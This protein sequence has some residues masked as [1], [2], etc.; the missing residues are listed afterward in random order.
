V[1]VGD[2]LVRARLAGAHA[3]VHA[4]AALLVLLGSALWVAAGTA[5]RG[6]LHAT[7]F[8]GDHHITVGKWKKCLKNIQ[9]AQLLKYLVFFCKYV[10]NLFIKNYLKLFHL[11]NLL[12]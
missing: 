5:L 12:S 3:A 11:N 6:P 4:E 9:Y 1:S 8:V 2:T 10:F 7:G